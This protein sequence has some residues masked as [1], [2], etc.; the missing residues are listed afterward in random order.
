MKKIF[1]V[2]TVLFIAA[3]SVFALDST[4]VQLKVKINEKPAVYTISG[5]KDG[6][7]YT[8]NGT[9]TYAAD[10]LCASANG[11]T[12]Y[13]KIG[14]NQ[15]TYATQKTASLTITFGAL[16]NGTDKVSATV[17][18]QSGPNL[19]ANSTAAST[20]ITT[21]TVSETF[22]AKTNYNAAPDWLVLKADY[23]PGAS[24]ETLSAGQYTAD[25]TL[26]YTGV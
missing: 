2:L 7:A 5:S 24:Y 17:T 18:K 16:T 11:I 14:R 10:A 8:Q 3:M 13:I 19:T 22:S 21:A 1:T 20:G 25:I 4:Q 6:S 12:A 23:K 26:T 15:V 9:L